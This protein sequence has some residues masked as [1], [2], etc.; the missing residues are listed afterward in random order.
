M[1]DV[2]LIQPGIGESTR[3][4]LRRTPKLIRLRDPQAPEVRHLVQL[5][6]ERQVLLE[7]NSSQPLHAVALIRSLSDG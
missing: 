1:S 6:Q 3:A 4:L 5:A 7:V 2:N